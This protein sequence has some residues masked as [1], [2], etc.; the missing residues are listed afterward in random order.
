ME[1]ILT[2]IRAAEKA[3]EETGVGA[4]KEA[5]EKVR[6]ERDEV[7]RYL[8]REKKETRKKEE[9]RYTREVEKT[10]DRIEAQKKEILQ[11]KDILLNN[12]TLT[13]E[14]ADLTASALLKD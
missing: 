11:Q 1:E 3:A 4:G 8:E 7:Y 6:R 2:K 13:R 5:E 12:N 14:V 10:R 9:E